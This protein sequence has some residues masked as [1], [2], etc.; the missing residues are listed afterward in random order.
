MVLAFLA[1]RK[2]QTRRVV[3][4]GQYTT[5]PDDLGRFL[6]VERYER[7]PSGSYRAIVWTNDDEPFSI[8]SPYGGPR[9]PAGPKATQ[10]EADRAY[11]K[12][13][14]SVRA[15]VQDGGLYRLQGSYLADGTQYDVTLGPDASELFRVRQNKIGSLPGRFMYA[16]QAR[17]GFQVK[18]ATLERLQDI[19]PEDALAEGVEGLPVFRM[20]WDR[21]NGH[22]EDGLYTWDNNPPCLAL[23][24]RALPP[25]RL[26]RDQR[27]SRAR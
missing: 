14:V 24:T 10:Y 8:A 25:P 3:P 2:L 1:G 22:R 7:Y 11:V 15:H 4:W 16:E 21:I 23:R 19:T 18:R 20:L 9:I 13:G 27:A 12:E 26:E 6:E 5:S 17:M